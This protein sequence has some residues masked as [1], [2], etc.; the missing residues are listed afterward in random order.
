ML[1]KDYQAV[2]EVIGWQRAVDFGLRVWE[3]CRPPSR[4]NTNDLG[5]GGTGFL[6]IPHALAGTKLSRLVGIEDAR[7]IIA[8]FAGETLQFPPIV[9]ASTARRN[10]LVVASLANGHSLRST[11]G[12]FGVTPRT[13][14][15]I[16]RAVCGKSPK[17][18]AKDA[19][20]QAA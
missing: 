4:A 14:L 5:G 7:K 19:K 12:A 16:T 3:T 8:R 2:A 1:A 6:Y 10:R 18:I 20:L 9:V 13:I 11:C 15:R 17:E